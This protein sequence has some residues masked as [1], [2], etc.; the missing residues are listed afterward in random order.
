MTEQLDLSRMR[1]I[2]VVN[3]RSGPAKLSGQ[4]M[5]GAW[6][7]ASY[8]KT[9]VKDA[10]VVYLDENNEDDFF[11][12]FAQAVKD[13][14]TACFSVTSMQIK[15][16]LPLIRYIKEKHPGMRVIT[17]GIHHILFP[18]QPHGALIDEAASY[19]LPRGSFLYEFLP[20]KVRETYRRE[21]AQVLTGFNC[22]FK[23]AFCVNSVRN[24]RYEA[25]PLPEILADLDY[26]AKEFDP[27]LVYFR[28]E[29]FFFDIE[30]AKAV[31]AHILEK[32]YRF[33]WEATSRVTNFNDIKI[34]DALLERMRKA[35]CV[36]LR[37]GVESGSQKTL[38]YLRKGQTVA[39]VKR[40]AAQCVKYGISANCSL[41]TGLP[42][43]TPADR[44]ETFRLITELH[45]MGPLVV[46]L[47]PQVYRPYPGGTIYEEVKKY[48]LKFPAAFEEWEN[49][50]DNNPTG[51]VFDEDPS[52]PW[53][54]AEE[55]KYLPRAWEV[56]H[57]GLNW[58]AS[59]NPVKKLVG[60]WF[61]RLHWDRRWFGG[62]DLALFM[63]IRKKLLKS[64]I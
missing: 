46:I 1:R 3:S 14:D 60:F 31:I 44:E 2:L 29:D 28:D 18:E 32:G 55:N 8:L 57:Y 43:E 15:H 64:G 50:Y 36:Q 21:R 59:S 23:C 38:N 4:V 30:K 37:F 33:K 25:R 26:V 5:W 56:V 12:K 34:N 40:A 35:G 13:R 58:S 49:F 11:A 62:P 22:S 7:V 9:A 20:E 47:G 63:F 45:E 39:Q 19:E 51:S 27:P 24:C 42:G 48:G 16:T 41:I 54:S 10:D 6:A 52:Y 61:K 17:G 53:L